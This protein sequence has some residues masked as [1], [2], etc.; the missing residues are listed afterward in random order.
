MITL[1]CLGK[2]EIF[3]ASVTVTGAK[4][5]RARR[6]DVA[7][8]GEAVRVAWFNGEHM[9]GLPPGQVASDLA[10][11]LFLSP[12]TQMQSLMGD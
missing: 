6:N 2:I 1:S 7:P 8:N 11:L 3:S 12:T 5:P 10:H 9:H 4:R